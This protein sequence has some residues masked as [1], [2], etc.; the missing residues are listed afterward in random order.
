MNA[1]PLDIKVYYE[2]YKNFSPAWHDNT[3]K[4]RL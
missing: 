3:P 1:V 4:P 2:E